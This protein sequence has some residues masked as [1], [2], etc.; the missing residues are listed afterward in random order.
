MPCIARQV[1]SCYRLGY[2]SRPQSQVLQSIEGQSQVR[3]WRS[4]DCIDRSSILTQRKGCRDVSCAVD[5]AMSMC[6]AADL[7]PVVDLSRSKRA[8]YLQDPSTPLTCTASMLPCDRFSLTGNVSFAWTNS[9]L[10]CGRCACKAARSANILPSFYS[11]SF[12]GLCIGLSN[13][14]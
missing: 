2:I 12:E 9:T 13:A 3:Y 14:L 11:K 4:N 8:N 6:S 1:V 7:I 10:V 5:N